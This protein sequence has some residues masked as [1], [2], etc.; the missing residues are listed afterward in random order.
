[1]RK[2]YL[3]SWYMHSVNICRPL[4]LYITVKPGWI[5]FTGS[6]IEIYKLVHWIIDCSHRKYL[7]CPLISPGRIP[8]LPT[9]HKVLTSKR[10][11][12]WS[13]CS[14]VEKHFVS[15]IHLKNKTTAGSSSH[16][17]SPLF[18]SV[19]CLLWLIKALSGITVDAVLPT[20]TC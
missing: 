1:M 5:D 11:P 2:E 18:T 9:L 4:Y 7:Q 17:V 8:I 12:Q 13:Q 14:F 10:G 15:T 19:Q 16:S 3:R 6:Y 20:L